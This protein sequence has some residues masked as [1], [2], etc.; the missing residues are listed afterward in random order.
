MTIP[1]GAQ[2]LILSSMHFRYWEYPSGEDT[3]ASVWAL[4]N[5][6]SASPWSNP[7]FTIMI[8][9]TPVPAQSSDRTGF[10]VVLAQ[11]LSIRVRKQGNDSIR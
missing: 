6:A 3:S 9:T 8:F 11:I 7:S 1:G 4:F 5:D 2:P 10:R